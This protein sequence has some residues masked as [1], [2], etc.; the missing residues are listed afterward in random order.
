[1]LLFPW[2]FIPNC[3]FRITRYRTDS[4]SAELVKISSDT[5]SKRRI[6]PSS[7]ATWKEMISCVTSAPAMQKHNRHWTCSMYVS[8]SGLSS[9]IYSCYHLQLS[10]SIGIFKQTQESERNRHIE[11]EALLAT[12]CS[13][14]GKFVVVLF[15]VLVVFVLRCP[16]ISQFSFTP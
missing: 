1:V 4:S 11:N 12:Y 5:W 10:V 14:W 9:L 3:R 7:N 6:D 13:W 16:F 8:P 15:T 2:L